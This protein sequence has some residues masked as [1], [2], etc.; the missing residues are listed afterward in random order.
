MGRLRKVR[1]GR[2]KIWLCKNCFT[3][4]KYLTGGINVKYTN[5]T[6]KRGICPL[7][8]REARLV[9]VVLKPR[10]GKVVYVCQECR[11]NILEFRRAEKEK[12]LLKYRLLR[13][14]KGLK[15]GAGK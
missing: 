10:T 14:F 8:G 4:F 13:S 3:R 12:L 6:L 11:I 2:G 9:K 1:F 7:C 5:P 15:V